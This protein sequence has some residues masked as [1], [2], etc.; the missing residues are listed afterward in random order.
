MGNFLLQNPSRHFET[1]SRT[2]HCLIF[3][4]S[5]CTLA[6]VGRLT[7]LHLSEPKNGLGKEIEIQ[8]ITKHTP[9]IA[10][11]TLKV[12]SKQLD[13]VAMKVLFAL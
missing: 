4:Q 3:K 7:I 12:N 10:K 2:V 1:L 13:N 6:E 11:V 5:T 8:H 9:N